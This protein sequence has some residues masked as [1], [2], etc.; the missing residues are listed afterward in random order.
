MNWQSQIPPEQPQTPPFY[1]NGGGAY[2]PGYYYSPYM[3]PDYWKK[4]GERR[5][6]AKQITSRA[7][8]I[9][10]GLLLCQLFGM[11]VV[12]LLPLLLEPFLPG[13]SQNGGIYYDAIEYAVYSPVCILL[14]FWLAS[15]GT[16]Q[17]LMNLMPF[18]KH[19]AGLGIGCI[20]FAFLG[21]GIGNYVSGIVSQLFPQI[22]QNL[23]GSLG[24]D[25]TTAIE[26]LLN[27]LYVAAIPALVEEF[28]FRGVTLGLL[29]PYGDSFAIITSSVLFAL[30]HGNF[31]QIPFAFFVGLVLAYAVVRTGSMVPAILIHFIN[32]AMSC[33]MGYFNDD[34]VDLLG[35]GTYTLIVYGLWIGLGIIG[36]LILKIGYKEKLTACF[37][38]YNGC[39]TPGKRTA[40]FYKSPTIIIAMILF[41]F[42]AALLMLPNINVYA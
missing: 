4:E 35:E 21:I 42:S 38:P 22:E 7:N 23:E 14:S 40:A 36:Y 27:V 16:R 25:P 11:I 9:G 26:L 32:N 39:I 1:S 41:L 18:G 17:K 6:F 3:D 30:M 12:F 29:R 37:H 8:W 34:L 33:F 20:L 10:A 31:I 13:A 2:S 19:K 5:Q 28:A 24:A 15:L